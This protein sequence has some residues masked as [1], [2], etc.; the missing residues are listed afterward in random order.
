MFKMP[1]RFEMCLKTTYLRKSQGLL[2]LNVSMK[3]QTKIFLLLSVFICHGKD[4]ASLSTHWGCLFCPFC[5]GL[6]VVQEDDPA[7]AQQ[8]CL[9]D[10]V[11]IAGGSETVFSI[12]E[13]MQIKKDSQYFLTWQWISST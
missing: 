3:L 7:A 6:S 9:G 11:Y 13:D 1:V 5:Q 4:Y 10:R 12:S 8:W 2:K